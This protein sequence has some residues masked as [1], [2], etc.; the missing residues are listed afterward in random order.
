MV[1]S[2]CVICSSNES[3][4]HKKQDARGLLSSLG[5]KTHISK[6]PLVNLL[7]F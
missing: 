4:F 6:I 1:L 7:L 2:S 5:I 3:R